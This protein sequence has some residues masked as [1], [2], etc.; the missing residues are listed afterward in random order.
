MLG[1]AAVQEDRPRRAAPMAGRDAASTSLYTWRAMLTRRALVPLMFS[2]AACSPTIATPPPA[3]PIV[4][5]PPVA[6]GASPAITPAMGATSAL[7]SGVPAN[8]TFVA[9]VDGK[10]LRAAPI[11]ANAVRAIQAFPVVQAK[12]DDLTG[13]CGVNLLEAIDEVVVA[14][15]GPGDDEDV[16][17]AR[18]HA[19]DAAVLRCVTSMLHGKP[20]TIGLD[21]AVRFEPTGVAVVVEGVTILGSEANVS[22]AI[23]AIRAHDSAVP[24]PARGLDLG[25]SVVA[26]VALSGPGFGGISSGAG[27]FEMDDHHLAIRA[28]GSVASAARATALVHEARA[29]ID[30]ATVELGA[31]PEGA[32]DALRA[33]LARIHVDANGERVHAEMELAG[34]AEAQAALVGT[35]SAVSIYAVRQYLAQAKLAEAKNSVGA[36]ARGLQAYMEM[37]DLKGKR[38]T[39][40]PPSAP[41]TPAKVP[42]GTKF[43]PDESTW[44][45]ATWKAIRFEMVSPSYY[46]YEIITSKDGHTATVRAHGD[47]DGDGKLST[48]ERTLTIEKNGDVVVS[49]RLV[50]IDE[51]E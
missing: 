35:L 50:L 5:S 41:P 7:L 6:S 16:T 40:F 9:R 34:G 21:P 8:A 14:R 33:Y 47:L 31:A 15:T 44:S 11:F 49:P 18:V 48:I 28:E 26:S 17:L 1:L 3:A 39:R 29:G 30:S 37:E 4:A 32:G 10:V 43:A 19:D 2:L 36:I 24:K 22:A 13:R 46:S 42:S 51:L 12:L 20:A 23:K 45:H 38:P 27:V 25:P